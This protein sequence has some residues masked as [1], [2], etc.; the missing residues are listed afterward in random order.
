MPTTTNIQRQLE[1]LNLLKCSLISGE[2]F[3]FI[4]SDLETSPW[5]YLL[6]LYAETSEVSLPEVQD[7]ASFAIHIEH[8]PVWFEIELPLSYPSSEPGTDSK[9]V[10]PIVL[11]R[12]EE[13]SRSEHERWQAIVKDRLVGVSD[14]EYV[15]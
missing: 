7:S 10:L 1:E 12:G 4:S 3:S 6:D 9:P 11:V 8:T 14:S 5:Q 15:S 2:S 13:I